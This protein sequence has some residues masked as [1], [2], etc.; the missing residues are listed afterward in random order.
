[1]R[2]DNKNSI[3]E[4]INLVSQFIEG[5]IVNLDKT[6]REHPNIFHY[7]TEI[8]RY[9][10]RLNYIFQKTLRS[11]NLYDVPQKE[12]ATYI[13]TIY[14]KIQENTA[15]KNILDELNLSTN[16]NNNISRF[17]DKLET[18]SWERALSG[19]SKIEILSIKEAIPTFVIDRLLRVMSF[20]LIK[21]NIQY[22]NDH[23]KHDNFIRISDLKIK[24]S[25]QNFID[26]LKNEFKSYN[27]PI[28][29]D[30]EIPELIYI[31]DD[32]K[33]LILKSRYY[34]SCKIIFQDKASAAVIKVLSPQPFEY[35]CDM[36][37]APGNKTNLIAQY[38]AN[39]A[40]VI[41]GEFLTKRSFIMSNLINRT[42]ILNTH[43]INCDSIQFPLRYKNKFDR[44]LL[45]APCTGSGTFLTNP[46]LKWRQ[47]K[48][49]LYQN[50]TI[51][52]K[53]I[54]SALRLLKPNGIFVYSTC[55]LY[56]EEGEL[57]ILK[58]INKLEPLQLPE[59]FSSSYK[60]NDNTIHGTGRLFPSIH[61]THGFFIAKFKKKGGY[62]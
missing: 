51:Q 15:K 59:W 13:Y 12:I 47:N 30:R 40:R 22:M 29:R 11:L 33:S 10:S 7:Y 50:I 5:K 6:N 49:F 44:V 54:E 3:N 36:C 60:I 1:M 57:Q 48:N 34:S 37:A 42:N 16:Q 17:I 53:L 20:E 32:K 41:A 55:S 45:D 26:I 56:P 25:N 52:E 39:Q 27:I 4:I 38:T 19:K 31:P 24:I 61:H 2:N 46:E 18:F 21:E 14:R 58:F 28:K 62:Y 43:L 23:R 35:I 9:W 8:V